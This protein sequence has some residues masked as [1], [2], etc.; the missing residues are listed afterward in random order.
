MF[1]VDLIKVGNQL[2]DG[3]IYFLNVRRIDN[4]WN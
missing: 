3:D 1:T 4:G 2:I